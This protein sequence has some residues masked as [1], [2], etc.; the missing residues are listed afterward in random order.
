MSS[1]SRNC[2][3]LRLYVSAFKPAEGVLSGFDVT[4]T[5][6]LE[7]AVGELRRGAVMVMDDM[8]VASAEAITPER[9]AAM[10]AVGPVRLVLTD[11]RAA[12]LKLRAYDG[13]VAR[14]VL[15]E[16]A[17]L[18]L[19][20]ALSDPAQDMSAPMKGPFET[21]RPEAAQGAE[22]AE[23]AAAKTAVALCK[24]AGLL[25]AALVCAGFARDLQ[26]FPRAVLE[27]A[28]DS[29]G[30]SLDRFGDAQVPLALATGARLYGFRPS[31]GGPDH[32]AVVVGDPSRSEPVLVRAHSE[33]FTGDLLGSLKCDCGPQLRTALAQISA[34]GSGVL[35]YLAQE[36][37]G[38]G[39]ANKLRAYSLQD[40]G[41]DTVDANH[42]LGF[43]DD[44]RDFR[45]AALMLKSLG[46]SAVRVM[47]NNPRKLAAFERH[48]FE[49]AGREPLAV[50]QTVE[51]A[52]YLATKARRSGHLL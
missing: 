42:R 31:D 17:R 27:L 2:Q 26:S 25:P 30:F 34:H 29:R 8:L 45:V 28:M 16:D 39:M 4:P 23:A 20:Q 38:I 10:Q 19:V 33:C 14:V 24:R 13:D 32:F 3:S 12:V 7:R 43:E 46:F 35:L 37:R 5:D 11:R 22:E 48:G 18:S 9:F 50:G 52:A 15:P 41:F 36:G 44:E 40:Q 51:N 21:L 6:Y 1:L 49:V 47:T